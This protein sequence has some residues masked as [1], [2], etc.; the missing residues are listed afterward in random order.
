MS[1]NAF[2]NSQTHEINKAAIASGTPN[3]AGG[4]RWFWWIAALSLVNTVL[5]HSGSQTSFVIGLGFTMIA[6]VAFSAMKPVAF[7]IDAFGIGFFAL[8]GWLALRGHFWAFIVGALVYA[9]D[10]LIYLHFQA[11]MPF[12]FHLL[13]LFFI[14]RGTFALRSALMDALAAAMEQEPVDTRSATP[15]PPSG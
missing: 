14:G 13:A 1:Y 4:A 12:G 5:I 8:M 2:V 3:V 10:A 7:A 9:L 6:D 11:M 15:P